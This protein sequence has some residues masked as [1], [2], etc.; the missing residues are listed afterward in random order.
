M[1]GGLSS[2][3][4]AGLFRSASY[5]KETGDLVLRDP[6]RSVRQGE[7]V[8]GVFVLVGSAW[9]KTPGEITARLTFFHHL[10]GET[11]H[12]VALA[13]LQS[14]VTLRD[15]SAFAE[16]VVPA[17]AVG[18]VLSIIDPDGVFGTQLPMIQYPVQST[19]AGR[20]RKDQ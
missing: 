4:V 3:P 13:V 20:E 6:V 12:E 17:D 1:A 16:L 2:S 18:C 14:E 15:P 8:N 7:P 10:G 11:S 19:A 9:G 5:N